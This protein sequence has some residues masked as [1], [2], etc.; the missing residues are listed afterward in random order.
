M[1]DIREKM[2]LR[3]IETI[4]NDMISICGKFRA[5]PIECPFAIDDKRCLGYTIEE[6]DY[7]EEMVTEAFSE[8]LEDGNG[9]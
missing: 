3:K 7:L 2:M 4:R 6:V 1:T 9:E 5:C 8:L